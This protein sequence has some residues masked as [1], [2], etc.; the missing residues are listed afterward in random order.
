MSVL[1]NMTSRGSKA[2]PLFF[3]FPS[4]FQLLEKL[5][6]NVTLTLS[7]VTVPVIVNVAFSL[8]F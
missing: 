6:L 4:F 8:T 2:A 5:K 1:W 3:F 7:M